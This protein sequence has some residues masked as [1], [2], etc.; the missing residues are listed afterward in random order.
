MRNE[1]KKNEKKIE[2]G[3]KKRKIET[4]EYVGIGV[5]ILALFG[6][7]FASGGI[8]GIFD[9]MFKKAYEIFDV[10]IFGK[11]IGAAIIVSVMTGRIL[12][13]L[14]LTDAL[15]RIFI[16]IMKYIGV[17]SAVVVP[18][19]YNILGD[20]NAAGRIAAPVLVK[21]KATKDE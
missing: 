10:F 2:I 17:N 18:G 20:I 3:N 5:F 4:I 12:E 13:R 14:G 1:E 7:F 15:M 8:A 19:V 6:L 9:A 21:A 16:P 11:N